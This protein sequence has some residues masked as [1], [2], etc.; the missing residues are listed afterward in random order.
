MKRPGSIL[1]TLVSSPY[2]LGFAVVCSLVLILALWWWYDTEPFT[3]E[4]LSFVTNVVPETTNDK[5]IKVQAKLYL[6]KSAKFPLSAVIIAPSSSGV[7]EVREVYY[8]RRLVEAGMAALVIDSFSSRGLTDSQYDQS[9]IEQWDIENDAIAALAVLA[10]DRRFK[11]D[12]I[13]IMGVS[14][15]GTV[16]MDTAL[17]IRRQWMGVQ[18]LSFA[19]HVAISPDCTWITRNART[20]GVPILFMLAE[21]DDQTPAK[22]C[23]EEAERIRNAGNERVET[24]VYKGAHHAWEELGNAPHYDPE[25]ENYSRCRVW[26]EDDG[27]MYSDETGELLPEDDWHS[28]AEENCM[29]LGAT[30]CGGSLTLKETATRDIIDFLRRSGL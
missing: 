1:S 26:I 2:R 22:P 18:D 4:D 3:T 24:K 15:G 21:L 10:A 19:A 13:A 6:P 5:P 30:C 16:S 27:K 12:R 29:F 9:L 7:E 20:T 11:A 17:E 25:V 14:K 23:L 8:A 28:W